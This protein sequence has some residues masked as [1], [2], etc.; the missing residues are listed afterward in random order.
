MAEPHAEHW[1][2]TAAYLYTLHLDGPALAWEYLR[3]NPDYR[4]DWLRRRRRPEAAHRWGLRLLEDPALD[5][6][7]AHPAWFPDHD[8][9]IQLYP[10]ADPPLE[11]DAFAFWRVPGDKH[12]I[13]DGKRLVL[14]SRRPGCCVRLALAPG[15]ED[16][17]AYLY[18]IRACAT[19][20][21]RYR[22]LAAGLDALSAATEAVP[23][24]ATRSRP[25]PA[26][27][28]ELHTLQSLDAS[29]A[30]ASLREV[31]EGLFGA[32]AVV[33][34]WHKDSALRARVRRLVRRGDALMRGGYRRLA[35][36]PP[37]L[38]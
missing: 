31:A 13:H 2:P 4:R 9:V 14:V 10:D 19:P 24:A 5:A 26:T 18:A 21:A 25:T 6:R 29:L 16:G 27:V 37:L 23:A 7:D 1:Y 34:D 28:L 17:M 35:Q 36:L 33:A 12:L 15:L 32:D 30:G 20:C 22:A 38:H 3:R 11:A 8:G